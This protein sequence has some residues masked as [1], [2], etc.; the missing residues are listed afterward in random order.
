MWKGKMDTSGSRY[1][2]LCYYDDI[3]SA[4]NVQR[5]LRV[6]KKSSIPH[7]FPESR[8]LCP[9]IQEVSSVTCLTCFWCYRSLYRCISD[10]HKSV[11]DLY[12]ISFWKPWSGHSQLT[13]E[14]SIYCT[15]LHK[16][17]LH[18]ATSLPYCTLAPSHPDSRRNTCLSFRGSPQP[19]KQ[20]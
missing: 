5:T 19:W 14:V 13:Q 16:Q 8:T 10:N 2:V 11:R 6:S 18:A 7:L 3:R 9:F 4:Y 20:E 15:D 17:R 1:Y 12:E